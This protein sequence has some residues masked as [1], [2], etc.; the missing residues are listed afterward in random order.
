[1]QDNAWDGAMYIMGD[2]STLEITPPI[3]SVNV[4]VKNK[5]IDDLTDKLRFFD[6]DNWSDANNA[7]SPSHGSLP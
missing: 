6:S 1:M 2:N 5:E 7:T 4:A 3:R